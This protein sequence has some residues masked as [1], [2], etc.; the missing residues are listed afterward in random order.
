MGGAR[1]LS[2][3]EACEASCLPPVRAVPAPGPGRG[4]GGPAIV[5]KILPLHVLP[6]LPAGSA[7][8]HLGF[9]Y[10]LQHFA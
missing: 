9:G 6:G 3:S 2:V 8:P 7:A 4:G 10:C 5:A 1:P